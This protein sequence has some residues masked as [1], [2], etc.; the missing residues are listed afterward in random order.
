ME[1]GSDRMLGPA[2]AAPGRRPRQSKGGHRAATSPDGMAS[3]KARRPA[4][5][6]PYQRRS[7]HVNAAFLL[8]ASAFTAGA[9]A[10]PGGKPPAPPPKVTAPIYPAPPAYHGGGGCCGAVSDCCDSC[11]SGGG[12][13]GLFS[14]FKGR[15]RHG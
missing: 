9:D 8:L 12:R 15:S 5:T 13:H 7:A 10:A 1:D 2:S 3:A 6:V 11:D 4:A 14:R